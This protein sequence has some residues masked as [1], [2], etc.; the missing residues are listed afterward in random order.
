MR[1]PSPPPHQKRS[2][3]MM[4]T[5]PRLT[6]TLRSSSAL[7][8]PRA[9][10][11]PSLMAPDTTPSSGLL[12]ITAL[13]PRSTSSRFFLFS[14]FVI[15][16]L[17]LDFFGGFDNFMFLFSEN[18]VILLLFVVF[19]GVW[20]C[21]LSCIRV[22]IWSLDHF[23]LMCFVCWKIMIIYVFYATGVASFYQLL[24]DWWN[25]FIGFVFLFFYYLVCLVVL[26]SVCHGNLL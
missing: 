15:T 11:S 2:W 26:F 24:F 3:R 9:A 20:Y 19:S 8:K 5:R 16:F 17:W 13:P 1:A 25:G 10:P 21:L 22:K 12:L 6:V 18:R 4:S 23:C 7:W 14:F